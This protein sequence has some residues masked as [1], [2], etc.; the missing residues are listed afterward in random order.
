[1]TEWTQ[2]QFQLSAKFFLL[3][4]EYGV[5]IVVFEVYGCL[6][7]FGESIPELIIIRNK[8]GER[9]EERVREKYIKRKIDKEVAEVR[10]CTQL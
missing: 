8:I 2:V 1:M 3:K 4:M 5:W 6:G 7:R 9:G 10:T